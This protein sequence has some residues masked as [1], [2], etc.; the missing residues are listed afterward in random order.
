MCVV[1]ETLCGISGLRWSELTGL[2]PSIGAL[3]TTNKSGALVCDHDTMRELVG[4]TLL[5]CDHMSYFERMD[6]AQ[7]W[8]LDY[9]AF[10]SLLAEDPE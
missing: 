2:V 9:D 6:V 5:I 4:E 1:K 7:D 8:D 10:T 3:R